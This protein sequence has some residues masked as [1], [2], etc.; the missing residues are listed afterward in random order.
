MQLYA[1]LGALNIL[2]PA[3]SESW[4]CSQGTN[5]VALAFA[6]EEVL[7]CM[8]PLCCR[9]TATVLLLR[10]SLWRCDFLLFSSR[11]YPSNRTWNVFLL[12]LTSFPQT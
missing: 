12:L 3:P 1:R 10:Y 9:H 6:T 2:V 5:F 4:S 7:L 8:L 11:F